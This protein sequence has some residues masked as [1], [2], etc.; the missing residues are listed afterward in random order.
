MTG[1]NAD[2]LARLDR[3]KPIL[4][5]LAY[6]RKKLDELISRLEKLD[7]IRFHRSSIKKKQL[8][9]ASQGTRPLKEFL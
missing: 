9:L 4:N 3:K 1:S 5:T 6:K 2:Y 8:M 7:S